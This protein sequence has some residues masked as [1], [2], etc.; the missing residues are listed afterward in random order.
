[1]IIQCGGAD[2]DEHIGIW[3]HTGEDSNTVVDGF[4]VSGAYKLLS[5]TSGFFGAIQV[6][7]ASPVIRHCTIWYNAHHG[8]ASGQGANPR[9]EDC[10]IEQNRTGIQ[11]GRHA[12]LGGGDARILRTVVRNNDSCGIEL[13]HY[14]TRDIENCLVKD[15]GLDGIRLY[16]DMPKP[17]SENSPGVTGTNIRRTIIEGN[18]RYG[19]SGEWL[20]QNQITLEC[21]NAYWNTAGDFHSVIGA[22][23]DA[24]GNISDYDSY[25][26]T[27]TTQYEDCWLRDNSPSAPANNSC[28]VQIGPFA[29]KWPCCKGV[30]GNVNGSVSEAPDLS[31]LSLLISYL[32]TTPRPKLPCPAEA[33]FNGI[34]PLDLSDL[35]R[36]I[37]LLTGG[38][39]QQAPCPVY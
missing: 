29:V 8:I 18:G 26:F 23:G 39:S 20:G 22:A 38:S 16:I 10:W 15:N 34:W 31:D 30:T 36:L 6:N 35:T 11:V 21:S 32:S 25:C 14:G 33:D 13:L 28:G 4:T 24:M 3:I 9:I 19:A 37:N 7:N 17:T 5:P 12:M 1:M 2:L 27:D